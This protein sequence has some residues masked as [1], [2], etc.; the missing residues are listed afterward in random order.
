M[1][2]LFESC[3]DEAL[4][5]NKVSGLT[6]A[7]T[8]VKHTGTHGDRLA[9][10]LD[11]FYRRAVYRENFFHTNT[12]CDTTHGECFLD[13]AAAAGDNYTRKDLDTCLIA[14]FNLEMNANAIPHLKVG[15]VVSKLIFRRAI[16]SIRSTSSP[17]S[18]RQLGA[19]Q[20]HP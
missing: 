3:F 1:C 8:H 18:K 2:C 12:R 15:A 9:V 11:F 19:V 13:S 7:I 14:F 16:S 6:N 4:F 20:S 5:L 17:I 10:D